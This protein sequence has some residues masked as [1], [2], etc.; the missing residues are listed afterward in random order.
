VTDDPIKSISDLFGNDAP[1]R[2][3]ADEHFPCECYE[4]YVLLKAADSYGQLAMFTFHLTQAKKHIDQIRSMGLP[5]ETS[6]MY[7]AHY[8][9]NISDALSKQAVS[10]NDEDA[11][12]AVK[13][14]SEFLKVWYS[15]SL[16]LN[17]LMKI[18]AD[19]LFLT[20]RSKG[21]A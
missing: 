14:V 7:Y 8:M 1:L 11:A 15:L 19:F 9:E 3:I 5:D 4:R 6:I 21:N 18:S 12:K 10:E 13:Q 2:Y 17:P 20:D 16:A